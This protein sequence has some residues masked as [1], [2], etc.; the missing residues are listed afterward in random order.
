[1]TTVRIAW[2]GESAH[3]LPPSA[4]VPPSSV[5]PLRV[6]RAGAVERAAVKRAAFERAAVERA[7][8]E[9]AAVERVPPCE[10]VSPT[11]MPPCRDDLAR[12]QSTK[13]PFAMT[14][15]D[16]LEQAEAMDIIAAPDRDSFT[17]PWR[18]VMIQKLSA[19]YFAPARR[20]GR[21]AG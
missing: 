18:R 5:P 20:G 19:T 17:T 8:V 12:A 4:A 14:P 21:G 9:R 7:A 10:C 11:S 6:E 2:I 15:K 1:V 16:F 13:F 3:E